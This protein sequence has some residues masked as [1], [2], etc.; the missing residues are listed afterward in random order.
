MKLNR[1][2]SERRKFQLRRYFIKEHQ[3]EICWKCP[4]WPRVWLPSKTYE[5]FLIRL[6]YTE[7]SDTLLYN[8]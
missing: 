2:L 8:S 1:C 6:N 5:F 7:L 3:P 4:K